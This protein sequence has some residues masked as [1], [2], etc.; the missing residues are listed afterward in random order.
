MKSNL[1]LKLIIL[2]NQNKYNLC[3]KKKK[4]VVLF[5]LQNVVNITSVFILF[6]SYSRLII[7]RLQSVLP[8][9]SMRMHSVYII[10]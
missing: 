8:Q 1:R 9:R 4:K 6:F 5:Y 2:A 10:L 3:T 7:S